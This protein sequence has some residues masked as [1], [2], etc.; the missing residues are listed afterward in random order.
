MSDQRRT[1]RA[2]LVLVAVAAAATGAYLIT[3]DGD[4]FDGCSG[5]TS[6]FAYTAPAR[7]L[8]S[9]DVVVFDGKETILVT[10]DHLSGDPSL[11][12]AGDKLVFSTAR[13]GGYY[14]PEYGEPEALSLFTASSTGGDEDRLT[15]GPYDTEPEWSPDGSLVVFVR[16]RNIPQPESHGFSWYE[17]WTVD[18]ET[19][20]EHLLLRLP[21]AP[22]EFAPQRLYSPIWSPDGR[23]VVFG[24]ASGRGLQ[25]FW[26]VDA[27]GSSP[28]LLLADAG[29][30]NDT[31]GLAWSP[32]GDEVAFV[33][34][35]DL[36]PRIHVASLDDGR[37]RVLV[38]GR[39]PAWSANG[40]RLAYVDDNKLMMTDRR[41]ED[42]EPVDGAPPFYDVY[43]QLGGVDWVTC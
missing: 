34:Q 3:S 40:K 38:Q 2:A 16:G 20:E 5:N 31:P 13:D 25:D 30:R 36:G 18:P 6:R 28:E 37:T 12:P 27:D 29:P 9:S 41:G 1:R 15:S 43:G 33:A 21:K 14:D 35:T 19:K 4:P 7:P 26:V 39:F 11:S 42:V 23:R 24:R 32:D 8:R 17:L 10:N 22:S